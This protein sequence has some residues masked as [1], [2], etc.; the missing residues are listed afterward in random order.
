MSGFVCP[1]CK[2]E[3]QIFKPSTGGGRRLAQDMNVPFLGAVPLDPRIGKSADYGVSFLDEY[4]D[5]PASIA[6]LDIIDSEHPCAHG[7]CL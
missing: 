5:S 6:Y 7:G 4:P 2:G 1:S 3:S